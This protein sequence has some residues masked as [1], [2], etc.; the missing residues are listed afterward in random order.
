VIQIE[1]ADRGRRFWLVVEPGDA[2][3]CYADP[4]CE[5]DALLRSDLA[6]LY[7]MWEG[8]VDLLDAVKAGSIE[9]TGPS[10]DHPR[11]APL[12]PAQPSRPE[13]ACRPGVIK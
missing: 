4:G 7:R 3:V 6:T 10:L 13:R 9:L 8:E 5:V 1:V 12:A 2:S 11:P